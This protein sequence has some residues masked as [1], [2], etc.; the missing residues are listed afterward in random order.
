MT[1]ATHI[2]EEYSIRGLVGSSNKLHTGFFRGEVTFFCVTPFT[3]CYQVE[4]GVSTA[5]RTRHNMV[6][7]QFSFGSA[8]LAFKIITLENILSRQID[9]FVGSIHIP[10]Q[11]DNGRHWKSTGDGMKFVSV[12]RPHQLAFIEVDQYKRTLHRTDHQR[13]E[14]L[15]EHEYT[16][17]HDGKDKTNLW[18]YQG[19]IGCRRACRSFSVGRLP[20]QLG[21]SLD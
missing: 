12:R 15:V 8:K 4:P 13:A 19:E 16:V 2:A 14:I 11:P 9:P 18:V 5:P 1:H 3:R 17:V 6:Q 20:L 7:R 10:V 21:G